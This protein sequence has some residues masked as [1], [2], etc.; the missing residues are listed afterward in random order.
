[1][2]AKARPTTLKLIEGR[3]NGRDSGGR[4]VKPTPGFTRLPPTA[5]A[6][7]DGEAKAMWEKVVPELQRLQ[8]LKPIDE[9]ALTAYCLTWQRLVDAQ[10]II[11]GSGILLDT[12][13]GPIK[14]PAVLIAET[15]SKELRAWSAE[16][17][18]TPSSEGRLG[19]AAADDDGADENPFAS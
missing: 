2:P 5:P 6:W 1:M 10:D 15:A 8:L 11:A 12:E 14:H 13:R 19:K 9:G 7:L 17:G 18:L 16:F 4:L 3:G